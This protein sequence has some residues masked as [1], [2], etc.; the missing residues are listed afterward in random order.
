M[1][2]R[3]CELRDKKGYKNAD[4]SKL[5][6]ISKATISDWKNGKSKPK[7]DKL[8][9]IAE[10]L[11]VSVD[12]LMTG[13]ETIDKFSDEN[14]KLVAKIRTDKRLNEIITQYL[15][16]TDEEKNKIYDVCMILTN[17]I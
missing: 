12:Y 7:V 15:A 4:I 16:S 13:K 3:Y 9:K 14:A 10:C 8:S 1:Y 5:T 17:K 6:G 2:N 11:G